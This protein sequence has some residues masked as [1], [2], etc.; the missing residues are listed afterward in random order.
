MDLREKGEVEVVG[1]VEIVGIVGVVGIIRVERFD[2]F[3]LDLDFL[4]LS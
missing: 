2:F 3:G 1:I 4:G